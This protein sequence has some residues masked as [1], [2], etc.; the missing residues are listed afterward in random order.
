[1][2]GPTIAQRAKYAEAE[3]AITIDFMSRL[4]AMGPD[5]LLVMAQEFPS[6]AEAEDHI[7]LGDV[8]QFQ[9]WDGDRVMGTLM[10]HKFRVTNDDFASGITIHKNT[11]L[12]DRLGF[13]APRIG[14]LAQK[15]ARHK[16]E[17][18]VKRLIQGFTG[19][20]F[21]VAE[22]GDGTS[23]DGSLF[24]SATHALEGGPTQSNV[25]SV[26]LTAA[27]LETA[28]IRLASFTTWDGRDPLELQ[29]THLIVGPKLEKTARELVGSQMVTNAAGTASQSNPYFQGRYQVLVS[30][31][32]VGD[33]DDYWF[34]ADL[35]KSTKPTLWQNRE[36]ITTASQIDMSSQDM[37]K[38]GHMNFGAQARYGF[39]LWDW[40]TII[41]SA[42]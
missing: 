17:H 9:R 4:E 2:N 5:P 12:D 30:R 8:P 6:E 15:A 10:A 38:R 16:G 29:G 20:A 28:E 34:L 35:S 24:F 7:F 41:G 23:F 36:P 13:I 14:E 22:Y 33:Y 32:L 42:L 39:G 37:F 31:R 40:R 18:L 26:A 1:M 11:I 19:T 25:M 3:V 27:N 21:N